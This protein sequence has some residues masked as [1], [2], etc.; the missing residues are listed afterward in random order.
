MEFKTKDDLSKILINKYEKMKLSLRKKKLD[1]KIMLWR[2]NNYLKNNNSFKHSKYKITINDLGVFYNTKKIQYITDIDY[3]SLLHSLITSNNINDVLY[4]L[5][6][7]RK[8]SILKKTPIK[9]MLNDKFHLVL[10]EII[11][12]YNNNI[13]IVNTC[14]VI[15]INLFAVSIYDDSIIA[16]CLDERVIKIIKLIL[17]FYNDNVLNQNVILLMT[18]ILLCSKN[19]MIIGQKLIDNIEFVEELIEIIYT[20]ELVDKVDFILVLSEKCKNKI[21][22][23]KIFIRASFVLCQLYHE[24]KNQNIIEVLHALIEN[25]PIIFDTVYKSNILYDIIFNSENE[26]TC[27]LIDFIT[28]IIINDKES[29]YSSDSKLIQRILFLL[30]PIAERRYSMNNIPII[31]TSVVLLSDILLLNPRAVKLLLPHYQLM[32]FFIEEETLIYDEINIEILYFVKSIFQTGDVITIQKLKKYFNLLKFI[33]DNISRYLEI[34]GDIGYK[35]EITSL[36]FELIKELS[37]YYENNDAFIKEIIEK[38]GEKIINTV[39]SYSNPEKMQ[40]SE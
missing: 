9:L 3:I 17:N 12:K 5:L 21:F 40:I 14:L 24:Y 7:C 20:N 23:N 11:D 27:W 26:V 39:F 30:E 31:K 8:Y 36:C 25:H 16:N 38:G 2:K 28:Q 32:K 33:I 13:K 18:N 10:F 19:E 22:P 4:G 15:L 34:E 1:E 37:I 6:L 29:K 35:K